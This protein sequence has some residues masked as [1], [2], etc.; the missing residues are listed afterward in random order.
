MPVDPTM[1][2]G[3]P[4]WAVGG[5]PAGV[6]EAAQPPSSDFGSML[7]QQIGK[8]SELQTEAADAGRALATGTAT[9][10]NAAVMAVERA[11]LSMQLAAQIR[12]K[13]V[14]SLQDI[15]RTQI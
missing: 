2:V 10:A 3:G 14:E 11:R 7:G 15:L 4:E 13:S 6:G 5:V 8:L 1:L 9:D 12:T